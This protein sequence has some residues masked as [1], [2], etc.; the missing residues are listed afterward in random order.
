MAAAG[1]SGKPPPHSIA[2]S[3][4][5][6]ASRKRKCR[7]SWQLGYCF[8]KPAC[9]ERRERRVSASHW[10]SLPGDRRCSAL[11]RRRCRHRSGRSAARACA[12]G[13]MRTLRM[14][15]L[16]RRVTGTLGGVGRPREQE[17][18]QRGRRP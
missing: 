16:S 11:P 4:P 18:G 12:A 6:F 2:G 3:R 10:R 5:A 8:E 13:G 14:P 17:R 15:R 9:E 7:G 1:L